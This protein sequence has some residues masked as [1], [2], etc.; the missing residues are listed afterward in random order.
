MFADKVENLPRGT[1]ID[2]G[3]QQAALERRYIEA[4]RRA[5]SKTHLNFEGKVLLQILDYHD[6]E[7]KLDPQRLLGVARTSDIDGGNLLS[8]RKLMI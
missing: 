6:E 7:R 3:L 5:K 4:L 8:W 2:N 1:R